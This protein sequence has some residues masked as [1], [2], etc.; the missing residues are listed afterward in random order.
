MRSLQKPGPSA[1]SRFQSPSN[2]YLKSFLETD[3]AEPA[4]GKCVSLQNNSLQQ[5]TLFSPK[6]LFY[7]DLAE[8]GGNEGLGGA[9]LRSQEGQAKRP[10]YIPFNNTFGKDHVNLKRLVAP[11]DS[12]KPSD[13][14]LN[15]IEAGAK[16]APSK[17]DS[18]RAASA[19]KETFNFTL[20]NSQS[21]SSILF[22]KKENHWE[23]TLKS[24]KSA[25]PSSGLGFSRSLEPKRTES[26]EPS[27]R[28]KI[29]IPIGYW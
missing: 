27:S 7:A 16:G 22:H 2:F 26:G 10:N 25:L 15:S 8:S 28:L 1:D 12:A 3:G 4:F 17:F 21:Y 23:N 9:S 5:K 14:I 13:I 18:G 19:E 20:R 11:G 24:R 29:S 6:S